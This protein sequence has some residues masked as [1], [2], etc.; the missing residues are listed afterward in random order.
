MTNV[1]KL[2]TSELAYKIGE[3]EKTSDEASWGH[4]TQGGQN[5]FLK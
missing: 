5:D 4:G 3:A 2:K 1:L